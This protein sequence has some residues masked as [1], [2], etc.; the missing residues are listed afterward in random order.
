MAFQ[1]D[2]RWEVAS[3][4]REG[5]LIGAW[6]VEAGRVVVVHTGATQGKVEVFYLQDG[7]IAC[8]HYGTAGGPIMNR[9]VVTQE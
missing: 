6:T 9:G 2:G 4:T 7:R 1:P 3:A 8:D 5:R